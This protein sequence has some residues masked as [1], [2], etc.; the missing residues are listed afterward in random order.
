MMPTPDLP[1][2]AAIAIAL[3]LVI[4]ALVTA[5]GSIG[6]LRLGSFYDR[7]HAPTLGATLGAASI[8]TAS[9][10]FFSVLGTRFVIHEIL[11]GLFV[12]VTT[13]VTLML[14]A[15]AALYRDRTEAPDSVPAEQSVHIIESSQNG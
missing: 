4:G 1:A 8:L 7:V 11:I 5:I 13:P 6:L 15:R 14:L 3:L 10:I 12:T 9:M 2:W